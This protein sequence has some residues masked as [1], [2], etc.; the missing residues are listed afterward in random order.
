MALLSRNN[1]STKTQFWGDCGQTPPNRKGNEHFVQSFQEQRQWTIWI[2]VKQRTKLYA[3]KPFIHKHLSRKP[4]LSSLSHI[5]EYPQCISSNQ[6]TSQKP[7]VSQHLRS[8]PHNISS[9][10][11]TKQ[12]IRS[13]ASVC[14][15]R[16]V[17]VLEESIDKDRTTLTVH[18]H[19]SEYTLQQWTHIRPTKCHIN[20]NS[21]QFPLNILHSGSKKKMRW[22]S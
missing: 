10:C 2:G 17:A 5:T 16:N 22:Q 6:K 18:I 1:R 8:L 4:C 13:I 9:T 15:H 3:V 19:N 14:P 7:A 21:I 12:T 20:M 11:P